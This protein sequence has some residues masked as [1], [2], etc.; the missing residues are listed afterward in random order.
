MRRDCDDDG[1]GGT[2]GFFRSV[3]RAFSG[4]LAED[5]DAPEDILEAELYPL[6]GG[7][8]GYMRAPLDDILRKKLVLI[9]RKM[10]ERQQH[11]EMEERMEEQRRDMERRGGQR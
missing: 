6:Y 9:G 2:G 4:K 1:R 7:Y 5:E 10:V 8:W 3:T 11:E